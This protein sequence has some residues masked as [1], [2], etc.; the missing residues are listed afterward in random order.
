M[1]IFAGQIKEK[2]SLSLHVQQ[3]NKKRYHLLPSAVCTTNEHVLV[4]V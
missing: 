2:F 1:Q 3:Q 4:D